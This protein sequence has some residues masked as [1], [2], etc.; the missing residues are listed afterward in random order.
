MDTGYDMIYFGEPSG[1]TELPLQMAEDQFFG[2]PSGISG[3]SAYDQ[4][5]AFV[6]IFDTVNA[7]PL[8]QTNAASMRTPWHTNPV[9][10]L[11]HSHALSN[12]Q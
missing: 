8:V 12:E 1:G 2:S 3:H 5:I 11:V 6:L 10:E 9:S 4:S 7:V